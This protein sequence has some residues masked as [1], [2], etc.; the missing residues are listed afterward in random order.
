M[1]VAREKV[2]LFRL[3]TPPV[4]RDLERIPELFSAI[5][6]FCHN[7]FNFVAATTTG[8]IYI[9]RRVNGQPGFIRGAR[10]IADCRPLTKFWRQQS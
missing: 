8:I 6:E 4:K 5:C 1:P 7:S 3:T 9:Q 10:I 2:K